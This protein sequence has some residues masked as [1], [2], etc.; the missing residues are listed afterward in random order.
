ML[1]FLEKNLIL[2]DL[3]HFLCL[4]INLLNFII[5]NAIIILPIIK[6]AF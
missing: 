3:N 5:I 6:D 1:K 2:T 4:K